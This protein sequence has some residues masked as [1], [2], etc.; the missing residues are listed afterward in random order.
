M[1]Y[2]YACDIQ[3]STAENRVIPLRQLSQILK[4]FSYYIFFFQLTTSLIGLDHL[5]QIQQ[6]EF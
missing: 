6:P 5:L 3:D 4:S 2:A 1:T